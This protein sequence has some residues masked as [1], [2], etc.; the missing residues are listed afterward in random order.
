MEYIQNIALYEIIGA[1]GIVIAFIAN[2]QKKDSYFLNITI[3]S[4]VFWVIHFSL[5]EQYNTAVLFI[6]IAG[7]IV[8]SQIYFKSIKVMN[9][10]ILLTILQALYFVK[11]PYDL[12]PITVGLI[13]SIANFMYRGIQLR[14]L[15]L[16]CSTIMALN[17]YILHSYT[18][19]FFELMNFVILSVTIIRLYKK[20]PEKISFKISLATTN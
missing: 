6:L 18:G 13:S 4:F 15:I 10:F 1:F 7:R 2:M 19:M 3:L 17:A 11:V 20:Q 16:S 8:L 5:I 12:L 14:I 9:F